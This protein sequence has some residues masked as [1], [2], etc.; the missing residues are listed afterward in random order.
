MPGDIIGTQADVARA[1][2][3]RPPTS[4]HKIERDLRRDTKWSKVLIRS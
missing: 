2:H 1:F 4:A 3:P